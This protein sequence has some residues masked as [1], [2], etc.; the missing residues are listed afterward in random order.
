M[1]VY[2]AAPWVDRDKMDPIATQLEDHG[3][4]LTHKWW[5]VENLTESERTAALLAEQATN[6]F[7]GV[8]NADFLLVINSSKSEGKAVEQGIGLARGI[9]IYIVGERGLH[10]A[11]VFHYLKCYRWHETIEEAIK[12]MAK[13]VIRAYAKQVYNGGSLEDLSLLDKRA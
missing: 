8:Y 5:K 12:A 2:L 1:K 3:F 10:S 11:N 4:E 13:T 9:P 6:D 7:V